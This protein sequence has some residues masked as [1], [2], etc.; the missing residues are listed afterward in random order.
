[1]DCSEATSHGHSDSYEKSSLYPRNSGELSNILDQVSRLS[2]EPPLDL[3]AMK[4]PENEGRPILTL[5]EDKHD[6][7]SRDIFDVYRRF[8]TPRMM[9][10]PLIPESPDLSIANEDAGDRPAVGSHRPPLLQPFFSPV[11]NRNLVHAGAA[12]YALQFSQSAESTA[13]TSR[14]LWASPKSI[15]SRPPP[16]M[17]MFGTSPGQTVNHK[18]VAP[19]PVNALKMRKAVPS[20]MELS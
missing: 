11:H 9:D 1:M 5:S 15:S 13:E 10:A 14:Y 19:Q 2:L 18:L 8:D 3:S 17:P 6:F 7:N 20:A 12:R 4:T 16:P